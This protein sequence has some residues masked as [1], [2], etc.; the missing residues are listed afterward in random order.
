M[1]TRAIVVS[2]NDMPYSVVR[3]LK[4]DGFCSSTFILHSERKDLKK[5]RRQA[6][7]SH[8]PLCDTTIGYWQRHVAGLPGRSYGGDV[9]QKGSG[10]EVGLGVGVVGDGSVSG[11]PVGDG[12]VSGVPVGEGSVSG[13]P[14]G[15]GSGSGVGVSVG[16]GDGVGVPPVIAFQT[17]RSGLICTEGLTVDTAGGSTVAILSPP[18]SNAVV[19]V[20]ET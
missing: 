17:A 9:R 12:S 5:T 15:D 19:P 20:G 16:V 7:G 8:L 1:I 3:G 13:V 14:V 18:A 2:T 4:S 6:Y 11:V 10:V